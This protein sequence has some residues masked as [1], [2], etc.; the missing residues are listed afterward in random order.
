MV[1]IDASLVGAWLLPEEFSDQ[2]IRLRNRL[3]AAGEELIAPTLLTSEVTST[4]RKAVYRKRIEA[5][6]GDEAYEAFK[7]FPISFHD[8]RELADAAWFW[9]KHVNAPRPLDM[10]YLALAE[11]EDCDLWTLDRRFVRLVGSRTQRLRWVGDLPQDD[12]QPA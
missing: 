12:E 2:A 1:C 3:H 9:T 10:F 6:F 5:D 11:R 8:L 7:S 4:L